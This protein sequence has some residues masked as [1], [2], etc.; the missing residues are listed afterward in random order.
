MSTHILCAS[1]AVGLLPHAPVVPRP[2]AA[3]RL[4]RA[5][6]LMCPPPGDA[7]FAEEVL[8]PPAEDVLPAAPHHHEAVP[9]ISISLLEHAGEAAA[10]PTP[11][12]EHAIA[13][14]IA[15]AD[16]HADPTHE[17]LPPPL[18]ATPE[19]IVARDLAIDCLMAG[20]P[21]PSLASG[22]VAEPPLADSPVVLEPLSAPNGAEVPLV[23]PIDP[24]TG[25][26]PPGVELPVPIPASIVEESAAIEIATTAGG[27]TGGEQDKAAAS[28]YSPAELPK[29]R[30][31]AAFCLPTLGIWL[32]S[33][34]LSLIDTSV[35]GL[36]CA[37]HHLAALAP[38]TK[39]CDYVGFFCSVIGAAT[40]NLAADAFARGEPKAA[41]R[42]IGG[43]LTISILLG[44]AVAFGLWHL[45]MPLMQMMLGATA[46]HGPM[47]TAASEY[48]AI[49]ALGYP[50]ALLT[51]S[52]Q[53][54][55]I[56]TKD[57]RSPLPTRRRTR[58]GARW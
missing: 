48:T 40:T 8:A 39:L 49:R 19:A 56:A 20:V 6:H 10:P 45:S 38:S 3:P 35:V 23:S 1:L 53:S 33:P 16:T 24:R 7:P 51:M 52:L 26:L 11:E 50:A 15:D 4:G 22:T 37:T 31:L 47:L 34:L 55:F 28:S 32:S 27:Q 25:M 14:V 17:G 36:S 57:S 54:A 44:A 5:A 43:S 13:D 41:K 30:D 18:A 58:R 29:L 42:V 9:L 21:N 12:S 46:S 2:S